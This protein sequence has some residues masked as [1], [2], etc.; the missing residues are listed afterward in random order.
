MSIGHIEQRRDPGEQQRRQGAVPPHQPGLLVEEV[1]G[2]EAVH[3]EPLHHR[4]L[5]FEGL[6]R[7]L[8][9]DAGPGPTP[10]EVVGAA[11]HEGP[12]VF[13]SHRGRAGNDD[14]LPGLG[15]MEGAGPQGRLALRQ[16]GRESAR[17]GL[18]QPERVPA[19]GLGD[20]DE[21]ASDGLPHLA[22]Q[23]EVGEWRG[24]GL[25]GDIEKP[26]TIGGRL[27]DD[28]RALGDDADQ[29]LGLNVAGDK[30]AD[31]EGGEH[32]VSDASG[33]NRP[34]AWEASA[35]WA[36]SSPRGPAPDSRPCTTSSPSR[37]LRAC[38]S[39]RPSPPHHRPRARGR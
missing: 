19:L 1:E 39:Q 20:V 8:A 18:R 14:G 37:P 28:H 9:P 25:D 24:I 2:A 22:G 34:C 36:R 21:A 32:G 33:G 7:S 10:G 31:E 13:D 16:R 35:L 27:A 6:A 5:G 29:H 30:H 3:A 17:A 4:E 15:D 23:R 38:Q 26:F 12:E 11:E